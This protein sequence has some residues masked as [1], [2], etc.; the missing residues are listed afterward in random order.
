MKTSGE[1]INNPFHPDYNEQDPVFITNNMR[2]KNIY[3]KIDIIARSNV[4]VIITG[5]SG[6]GKEVIAQLIHNK[7]VR[8]EQPF[9]A[10]NCGALPRDLV[11]SELFGH[12]KGAF[13]GAVNK[14]KGC[15]EQADQGTMFFDEIA[16]MPLDMQVKLLRAVEQRS[17]RRVGGDHEVQVDVRIISATNK[18]FP[19]VITQ[20]GFREDLYYRL[21]VVELDIPPLRERIDDIQL[22]SN[23]F[24]TYFSEKYKCGKKELTRN[25]LDVLCGYGWPGNVREL[26][27]IMERLTILCPQDKITPE[28]L[29]TKIC[30]SEP[31]PFY[32][33][34]MIIPI[35]TPLEEVEKTMIFRTL[36]K[37]ENNKTKAAKL[38][39]FSR[40]TLHNK[41]EKF[42]IG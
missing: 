27:N 35:G 22:L 32:D 5:E 41:L 39:G 17:F 8:T 4:S 38:L 6:T 40:K 20:G 18:V 19:D 37:V 7:S 2:M 25:T 36:E 14:K 23:Y 30:E 1:K 28:D 16:E 13:T 31:I 15:F 24:L 11:E 3:S 42:N 33:D 29:P 9:V 10:L 21:G 26:K 12:E 34:R